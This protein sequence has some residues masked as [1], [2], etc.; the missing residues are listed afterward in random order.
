MAQETWRQANLRRPAASEFGWENISSTHPLASAPVDFQTIG[1]QFVSSLPPSSCARLRYL[2]NSKNNKIVYSSA[3]LGKEEQEA[4]EREGERW[5]ER[6][7]AAREKNL[8][9]KTECYSGV[10]YWNLKAKI[11]KNFLQVLDIA[12]FVFGHEYVP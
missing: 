8:L 4:R 5:K 11:S 6:R 12:S 7:E 3:G 1:A 10:E 9:L 2:S